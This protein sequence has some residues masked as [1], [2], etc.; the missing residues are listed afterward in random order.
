VI[1]AGLLTLLVILIATG[2]GL[3]MAIICL[4]NLGLV[5][6]TYGK[7]TTGESQSTA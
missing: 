5:W 7:N 3:N 4:A 2:Q 1:A 6:W